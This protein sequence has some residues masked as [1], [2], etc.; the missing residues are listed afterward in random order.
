MTEGRGRRQ[1]TADRAPGEFGQIDGQIDWQAERRL[2]DRPWVQV[3][4]T[5]VITSAV[6]VAV[7]LLLY[8]VWGHP[9]TG[10]MGGG[11]GAVLVGLWTA[12]RTRRQVAEESGLS[13]WQVPIVGR[14]LRKG[15]VPT[16]PKARRAMT[17]LVRRQ[18]RA[19]LQGRWAMP[20]LM[21]L[22]ALGGV[23]L[24]VTGDVAL[25][26]LLL[27]GVVLLLPALVGQRRNIKRLPRIERQLAA[28]AE[29][30]APPPPTDT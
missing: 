1:G 24:L 3:A 7:N 15:R 12:R 10:G 16:D 19:S 26:G 25:G 28:P 2:T 30:V 18:Q 22:F 5:L 20:V 14:W 17:A 8:A 6:V 29:N 13:P 4:L 9:S 11:I 23:V 21:T 27:V